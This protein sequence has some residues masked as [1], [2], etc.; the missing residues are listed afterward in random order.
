MDNG[1]FNHKFPSSHGIALTRSAINN[2]NNTNH[3]NDD[4]NNNFT[5]ASTRG[6]RFSSIETNGNSSS[7]SSDISNWSNEATATA[8]GEIRTRNHR[9]DNEINYRDFHEP[10]QQFRH[11]R[12]TVNSSTVEKLPTKSYVIDKNGGLSNH[13]FVSTNNINDT[14]S[15]NSNG[16]KAKWTHKTPINGNIAV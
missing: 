3:D 4:E 8:N 1:A 10:G 12:W 13:Q 5:L 2:S 6:R 16:D 9:H 7:G 14:H 11:H 15:T